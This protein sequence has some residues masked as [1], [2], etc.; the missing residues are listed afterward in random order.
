MKQDMHLVSSEWIGVRVR[1]RRAL[2]LVLGVVAGSLVL[3]AGCA[4]GSN[5]PLPAGGGPVQRPVAEPAFQ[6]ESFGPPLEDG[7]PEEEPSGEI[8]T[9]TS[10]EEQALDEIDDL[11]AALEVSPSIEEAFEQE[12]LALDA[13]AQDS[14]IAALQEDP[15]SVIEFGD[16][17]TEP[18]PVSALAPG[19]ASQSQRGEILT[20]LYV[21]ANDPLGSQTVAVK[22]YGLRNVQLVQM[23]GVT[24]GSFTL[25]F[26]YEANTTAVTRNLHCDGWWS[27]YG[28]S[29]STKESQYVSG[30]RGTCSAR[31]SMSVF[32]KGFPLTFNKLH[33]VSTIAGKPKSVT[34]YIKT[35]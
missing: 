8:L 33:T 9:P 19:T 10:D 16:A 24:F 2:M 34:G 27:G 29:G 25:E 28:L 26:K 13:E 32:F 30:G 22:A 12:F 7:L 3:L 20:A 5:F 15:L 31:H 35:V 23:L 17:V 14:F 18:I 4:S 21:S 11:A 1:S 6:Q